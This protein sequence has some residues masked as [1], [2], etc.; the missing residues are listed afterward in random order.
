MHG[1]G[2]Y[3]TLTEALDAKITD[4]VFERL[5]FKCQF[6]F[7]IKSIA[8]VFNVIIVMQKLLDQQHV[9]KRFICFML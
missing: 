4:E 1:F 3:V 7:F 2:S 8:H 9:I 5:H 6:F